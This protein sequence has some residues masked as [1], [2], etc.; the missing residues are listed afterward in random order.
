M[1]AYAAASL[2]QAKNPVEKRIGDIGAPKSIFIQSIC[3]KKLYFV[4]SS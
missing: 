2:L 1:I 4:F 3:S